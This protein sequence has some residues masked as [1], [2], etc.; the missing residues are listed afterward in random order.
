MNIN[1]RKTR[2]SNSVE[3]AGGGG[4]GG[5]GGAQR[6]LAEPISSSI[7]LYPNIYTLLLHNYTYK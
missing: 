4:G 5:G 6:G 2:A 3:C 7:I 1:Q